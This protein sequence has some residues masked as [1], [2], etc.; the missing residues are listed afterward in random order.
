ML[1]PDTELKFVSKKIGYGVFATK[2]ISRGTLIWVKDELDRIFPKEELS[3]FSPANLDNFLK[4]T[5]RTRT[6]D[7]LFCWDLTRYANHS[8]GPNSMLTSL[9]FEIAI[10]DINPGEEITNDYGTLNIIEPFQCAHDPNHERTHVRPDDLTRFYNRWD[11]QILS[12]FPSITVVPQPLKKFLT[13]DLQG[14][15]QL[16]KDGQDKLPSVL[17]NYFQT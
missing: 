3:K 6:G 11:G 8:F 4:Y 2:Y 16:I 1:H 13:Q 15:I 12:V 10:R 14:R 5:Y 7:Y 9:G 17:T